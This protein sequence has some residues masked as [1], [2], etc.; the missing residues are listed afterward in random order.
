M[1]FFSFIYI[2]CLFKILQGYYSCLMT[3]K[4]GSVE[5][6]WSFIDE[7]CI[8]LAWRFLELTAILELGKP[9]KH[10]NKKKVQT[11]ECL[12]KIVEFVVTYHN[13]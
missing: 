6:L 4:W 9:L 5:V 1:V 2:V 11:K 12:E 13:R 8:K 10:L 7:F 3:L